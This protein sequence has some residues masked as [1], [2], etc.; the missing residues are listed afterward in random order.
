MH[1]LFPRKHL[2]RISLYSIDLSVVHDQPVGMCPV[3]AWH[4]ICGKAGVD[5]G[6]RRG[7]IR[8]RQIRE[9]SAQLPHE[10]HSLVYD[11]PA[12]Q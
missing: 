11:I 9:E 7:I 3:P 5:D 10:E 1:R 2:V 8:F 12:G 4:G 6:H